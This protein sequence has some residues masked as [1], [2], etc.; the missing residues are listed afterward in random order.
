MKKLINNQSGI[1]LVE[2]MVAAGISSVIALS[3]MKIST[4]AQ[5]ASN[6]ARVSTDLSSF[7]NF[8]MRNALSSDVDC[9]AAVGA[10]GNGIAP[11]DINNISALTLLSMSIEVN[12][13]LPGFEQEFI[14]RGIL[15]ERQ[16]SGTS[17]R[18]G[19]D[20]ERKSEKKLGAK[21]FRRWVGVACG[22]DTSNNL[23]FCSTTQ[24]A[25]G[26]DSPWQ[27]LNEYDPG[28]GNNLD[29]DSWVEFNASNFDAAVIGSTSLKGNGTPRKP[30][31]KFTISNAGSAASFKSGNDSIALLNNDGIKWTGDLWTAGANSVGIIGDA[32]SQCINLFSTAS[33][34]DTS[35]R[36][37]SG[38]VY[39][40]KP[41]EV[42][43]NLSA[44]G[45]VNANNLIASGEV[46]GSTLDI[47][48]GGDVSG[49]LTVGSL[50]ATGAVSGA[51]VTGGTVTA[52]GQLTGNTLQVNA[53]AVV[54]GSVS[55]GSVTTGTMTATGSATANSLAVTNNASVGG[56]LDVTGAVQADGGLRANNISSISGNITIGSTINQIN[57][58]TTVFTDHY[59][60]LGTT[61]TRDLLVTNSAE[62]NTLSVQGTNV[63]SDR[64]LKYDIKQTDLGLEFINSL[65]PVR[66]V[67]K[68]DKS[69]NPLYRVG[70]IAQ[71]IKESIQKHSK[72]LKDKNNELVVKKKDGFFA[73]S[74]QSLISP[75]INAVK[76]LF[77]SV[78]ANKAEIA[79]LKAENQMLKSALCSKHDNEFKF[80]DSRGLASDKK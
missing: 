42:N 2:V 7:M 17:C 59:K 74:Y 56:G 68:R 18:I 57:V 78:E 31:S 43:G 65:K 6:K 27:K 47:N 29:S 12:K 1:S 34:S 73:V 9:V 13:P 54:N 22:F 64:R 28:T 58:G 62:I 26:G 39:L 80:C 38:M 20:L 8:N 71:D 25:T 61:V 19:L 35:L 11:G 76:E 32:A 15:F 24:S 52:T 36:A 55:S 46:E 66:Y 10:A 14:T 70:L 3:T 41:V 72:D 21:S 67:Y 45:N 50:S 4:N 16:A 77:S 37:C 40:D 44:L 5:K 63:T 49:A 23:T 75:I 48:G 79:Q 53:N 69:D 30:I 60:A 51:S 33:A